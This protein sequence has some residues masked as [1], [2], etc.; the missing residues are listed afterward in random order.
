MD[1]RKSRVA[2]QGLPGAK[3]RG[4][5]TILLRG[6]TRNVCDYCQSGW[7]SV[8]VS[9]AQNLRPPRVSEEGVGLL[10]GR[11]DADDGSI[12]F[13]TCITENMCFVASC[14]VGGD[15]GSA[16]C[17]IGEVCVIRLHRRSDGVS[18]V[19]PSETAQKTTRKTATS[20]RVLASGFTPLSLR[21]CVANT[22]VCEFRISLLNEVKSIL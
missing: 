13:D 19:A 18:C 21:Y 1:P 6:M 12:L 3:V 20:F 11:T 8:E 10:G 9:G 7:S 4:A 15:A 22:E 5:R 14:A 17:D 2:R 16:W